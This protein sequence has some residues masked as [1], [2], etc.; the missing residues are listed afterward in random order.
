[1]GSEMCIR[2]RYS[3]NQ[4]FNRSRCLIDLTT[5]GLALSKSKAAI[6]SPCKTP[7]HR[8]Q[9]PILYESV[10]LHRN[11]VN[12]G[13]PSRRSRPPET[14]AGAFKPFPRAI[15]L[16]AKPRARPAG[17]CPSFPPCVSPEVDGIFRPEA[18]VRDGT[19]QGVPEHLPVRKKLATRELHS[20]ASVGLTGEI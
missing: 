18:A 10:K 1:M 17:R 5:V 13:F 11:T 4:V 2:D 20:F 6:P 15:R 16:M 9:P 19:F 8:L 7:N 12:G 14:S 3:R